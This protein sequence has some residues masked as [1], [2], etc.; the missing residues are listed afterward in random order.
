MSLPEATSWKTPQGVLRAG[1][2]EIVFPRQ[3]LVM[4][5]INLND[6]SFSGDGTLNLEEA[7]ER[8][9]A[10]V[11]AGA[12]V[13]DAGGESARTNR[14]PVGVLEEVRRVEPF[15]R[16]FL[17]RRE[18]WVPRDDRQLFPPLLSVNTWRPAVA[19]PLLAAG[20]EM[21]NDMGGLVEDTNA[22]LAARH[23]AALL[24][25]H[26]AGEPKVSHRHVHY[27][28]VL[29]HMEQFFRDRLQRALAAGLPREAVIF[30]PGLDFAKQCPDNLR[31]L[32]GLGRISGLGR[33][34][35]VPVS[36][37]SFIGE[38]LG[39]EEPSRRDAGT[40]A[41]LVAAVLRGGAILRVHHVE[42]A[43]AAVRVL[44][45]VR[46]A[47]RCPLSPVLPAADA[48]LQSTP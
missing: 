43:A 27:E 24:I 25:M 29:A 32:S 37:K 45:S 9:R 28:D 13:I 11:A 44:E 15:V 34:V 20:A 3:P 16:E 26:T 38:V 42:A 33:P 12:D 8:A 6:D 30:D 35:L 1:G 40:V 22:R 19:Q 2:R 46:S 23:R 31:V 14:G 18:A 47:N 39:L 7:L 17:L 48:P 41:C 21:L 5:I 10:M 4:G 36:R